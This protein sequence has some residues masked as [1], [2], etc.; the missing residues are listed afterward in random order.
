MAGGTKKAKIAKIERFKGNVLEEDKKWSSISTK[1]VNT[2]IEQR[3]GYAADHDVL[4]LYRD[5]WNAIR[6]HAIESKTHA[7]S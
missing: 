4:Q 7:P 1:E 6:T 3:I 2:V 5:H